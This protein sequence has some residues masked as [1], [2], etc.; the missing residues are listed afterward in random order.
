[1]FLS[2]SSPRRKLRN[3][4]EVEKFNPAGSFPTLVINNGTRVI[5]DFQE[6]ETGGSPGMTAEPPSIAEIDARYE[7]SIGRR[8]RAAI[9]SILTMHSR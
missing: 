3:D 4:Q 2:I 9:T 5:V 7:K 8:R 6:H 1:M